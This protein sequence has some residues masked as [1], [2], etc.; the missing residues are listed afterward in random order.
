VA[1]DRSLGL[2]GL[3]ERTVVVPAL[4]VLLAA[5]AAAT[6]VAGLVVGTAP[7]V[8]KG[9]FFDWRHW[10]PLAGGGARVSVGYVWNETYGPLHF[11]KNPTTVFT[12]SS[13]NPHYWKAGVLTEFNGNA[14]QQ[15][16]VTQGSFHDTDGFAAPPSMLPPN[17]QRPKRADMVQIGVKIDGLADPHL[18]ATGQATRFT[19]TSQRVDATLSTDGTAVTSTDLP[20][21]ATYTVRSYAPNPTVKELAD[22]GTRFPADVA[23]GIIVA[24]ERIPVWGSGKDVRRVPIDPSLVRASNQAWHESGADD[25]AASEYGA[26]AALESYF[27]GKQFH[28]DQTPPRGTGPVLADFMLRSHRGYCQMFSGAMALVLRLHGIPARVAFGFTEGH[29][30]T[31]GDF[32]V[33]DRDAHAWVEAYF[34]GYGWVSFEPTA[35]RIPISDGSVQDAGLQD[36]ATPSIS[37]TGQTTNPNGDATND[38]PGLDGNGNLGISSILAKWSLWIGLGFLTA[39]GG[40]LLGLWL[41][42]LRGLSAPAR[43]FVRM[44]RGAS[45]SGIPARPSMTPYEYAAIIAKRIPG[46]EPYARFLAD[47]YVRERYG[48]QP[49]TESELWKARESWLQLRILFLRYFLWDRWWLGRRNQDDK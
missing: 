36:A 22:A 29:E 45:W 8:A 30:T 19:L 27:H 3:P 38:S 2:D 43:F 6:V 28:Y 16:D 37:P 26:V 49:V 21:D 31:D 10:N 48:R 33:L 44:H 40:G 5:L 18:I 25:P 17:A 7:G 4:A 34:P 41:W 46:S 13:I 32:K 12:V 1:V 11:P 39:L 9:A 20:R 47:L 35:A 24:H 23:A 14:W 15:Q 42:G